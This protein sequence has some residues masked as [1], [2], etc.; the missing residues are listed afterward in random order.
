MIQEFTNPASGGWSG[1]VPTSGAPLAA[2]LR[3]ARSA[4][5]SSIQGPGGASLQRNR[6]SANPRARSA[7][8][9]APSAA[10]RAGSVIAVPRARRS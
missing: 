1:E 10:R 4:S 3:A 8:S 2:A 7:S 5:A 9:D 6:R